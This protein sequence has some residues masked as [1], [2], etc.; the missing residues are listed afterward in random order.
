[1]NQTTMS[2]QPPNKS[3]EITTNTTKNQSVEEQEIFD[4]KSFGNPNPRVA[5]QIPEKCCMHPYYHYVVSASSD[6]G[7]NWIED[8]MTVREHAS[9]PDFFVLDNGIQMLY[10][11]DG[12]YDTLGCMESKDGKNFAEADCR[13]Y[14][15]TK[16]KIWDPTVVRTG[17]S[18]YRLFF[19]SPE[20]G[21]ANMG[22]PMQGP[23]QVTPPPPNGKISSA[24]SKNGKDWLIESGVRYEE[25]GITDPSVIQINESKWYLFVSK[26]SKV[27]QSEST[28][29]LTF[30]KKQELAFG[31]VPDVVKIGN[32]YYLFVCTNGGISYVSSTDAVNWGGITT[33]I[34]QNGKQI[35]C[36][37]S[38]S[39]TSNGWKMY[40]KKQTMN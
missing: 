35:I 7:L 39:E 27:V 4:P 21:L 15:F 37:P 12:V 24:I 31:G 10:F 9:V 17:N 29:G 11:V 25:I 14:N 19:F 16:E 5:Q 20:F 2:K 36:D 8:V 32:K 38:I 22:E 26:G 30:V 40:F 3:I 23:K 34:P 13:V 18:T 33:A 1:M 28:D 6:N